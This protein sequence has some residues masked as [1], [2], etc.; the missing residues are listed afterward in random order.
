MLLKI[1]ERKEEY[2]ALCRITRT[3]YYFAQN[4]DLKSIY[5]AQDCQGTNRTVPETRNGGE[6]YEI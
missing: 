1:I 2:L 3:W 6:N 5:A 4:N